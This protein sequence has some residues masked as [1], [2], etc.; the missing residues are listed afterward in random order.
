MFYSFRKIEQIR[1]GVDRLTNPVDQTQNMALTFYRN[2]VKTAF[3]TVYSRKPFG[4]YTVGATGPL[5]PKRSWTAEMKLFYQEKKKEVPGT[6]FY[7]KMTLVGWLFAVLVVGF[8]C[9][10]TYSS[11]KPPLSKSVET[12]EMAQTPSVGDIYFGHFET[13]EEPGNA[14][15]AT[16][17]FGW[18]KVL[19]VNGNQ[20][21]LAKSTDMHKTSK[22][23]EQLNST[24][25]EAQG[26]PSVLTEQEGYMIHF[27]STDGKTTFYITDKK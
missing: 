12:M 16:I 7:F 11:L 25:F 8:F 27:K 17:G 9:Y 20:Y 23:K 19:Q 6:P 5:I 26:I 10:L 24:A 2:Q 13:Y 1:F 15:T 18:F 14:L 4:E 22:P 21:N 3:Y